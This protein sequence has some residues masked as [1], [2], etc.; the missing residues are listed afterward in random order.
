MHQNIWSDFF[1]IEMS[2]QIKQTQTTK[3]HGNKRKITKHCVFQGIWHNI[4]PGTW[5]VGCPGTAL[6]ETL[7]RDQA[8]HRFFYEESTITHRCGEVLEFSSVTGNLHG[9]YE[10]LSEQK[11]NYIE[12]LHRP[13]WSA[14]EIKWCQQLGGKHP[15]KLTWNLN[16]TP[17][18]RKFIFQTS[19]LGFK[20]L[21]NCWGCSV[22]GCL[23]LAIGCDLF[24]DG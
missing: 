24:W 3:I 7:M 23:N 9:I 17:L 8:G 19:I 20:M 21:Y 6:L 13:R 10:A 12:F 15:W 5:V 11:G 16:I 1:C 18:K 2:Y 14:S 22:D 4:C